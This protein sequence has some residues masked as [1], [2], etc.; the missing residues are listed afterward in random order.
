M[1][2]AEPSYNASQAVLLKPELVDEMSK[3]RQP[4]WHKS[5]WVQ[6]ASDEDTNPPEQTTNGHVATAAP[7]KQPRRTRRGGASEGPAEAAA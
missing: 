6:A 2:A 4:S 1:T 3:E 5:M 7:T